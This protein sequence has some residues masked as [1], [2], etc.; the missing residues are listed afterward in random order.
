MVTR[1]GSELNPPRFEK[2]PCA[3]LEQSG[4]FLSHYFLHSALF[5]IFYVSDFID[6]LLY[7]LS[8]ILYL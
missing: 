8:T 3:T 7:G 4:F 6:F 5:M 1:S 2:P